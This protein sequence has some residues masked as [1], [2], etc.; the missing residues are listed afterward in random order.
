MPFQ[1]Q[2]N[3][4]QAPA[5]AGDFADR[6][7]RTSLT[8][9]EGALVA[10][11]AGVVV[12][13]FAWT[14]ANGLVSNGV[15]NIAASAYGFVHREQQALITTYLA[16]S[17]NVIRP[18]CE[19]TLMRRGA[20]WAMF[21]AGATFKQRVYI[22]I[23]D[24]SAVAAAANAPATDTFTATTTSGSTTINVTAVNAGNVLAM[25]QP[26]SGT[27]IPAGA[28]I[29]SGPAAGGV[30]AYVIS[31]AATAAGSVT[32]TNTKTFETDFVV[33]QSVLAGEIAKITTWGI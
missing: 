25:G 33:A 11:A 7:P 21:A 19:M 5:V 16:E 18:G 13:R 14:D 28:Y 1:S 15:V 9:G 24:G 12:G 10:G 6:N 32:V 20:F 30:G 31:A 23:A 22:N 27:G 2:V 29:V 4:Y 17:G 26:I 3:L 8:A